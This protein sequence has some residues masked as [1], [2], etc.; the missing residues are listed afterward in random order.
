M[1]HILVGSA[2]YSV[3]SISDLPEE[4]T[5]IKGDVLSPL[6]KPKKIV[7]IENTVDAS[8]SGQC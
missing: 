5:V 4:F 6:R 3:Y 1:D 7:M 8:N 2:W